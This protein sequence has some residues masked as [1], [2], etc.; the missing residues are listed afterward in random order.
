MRIAHY[1][2]SRGDTVDERF[3]CNFLSEEIMRTLSIFCTRLTTSLVA[4]C[5][6]LFVSGGAIAGPFVF[7]T[8][9][10]TNSIA[11]ASRPDLAGKFEI[12]GADDFVT[13]APTVITSATFTGLL[14]GGAT[15]ADIGEVRV[16]I[17]RVFPK[18]SDTVRTPNV[19]TRANSPSDVA[20]DDRDSTAG[21]GLIFSTTDLGA[22]SALNSVQPGGIHPKGASG[23][24]Q[25]T[26]GDGPVA[27]EE[28][29]FNIT[30]T[31]PF[32]LPA[33]HYFFIPQVQITTANGEFLWLSASRPI[34]PPGT[35]FPAGFTDLQ[36]WTRDAFLDPDWSRVGTDIVGGTPAP[37]FNAA[38]SLNGVV[39]EPGTTLLL[40]WG[41]MM[42]GWRRRK[43]AA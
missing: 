26:G 4:S 21:G 11:I 30:F 38:F 17:Y 35:S 25:T 16:E 37:T 19:V 18:D 43:S 27:G 22:L 6:V 3:T 29:Q 40:G 42:L 28:V 34:V 14:S 12:E 13:T 10:V 8:G 7:S 39:P 31:T 1:K 24:G 41:V 2:A 36:S 33:D 23:T 15:T 9:N 5:A 32:T 20:L